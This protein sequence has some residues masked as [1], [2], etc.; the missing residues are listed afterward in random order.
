MVSLLPMFVAQIAT[1][2]TMA[3]GIAGFFQPNPRAF[4]SQQLH[5]GADDAGYDFTAPLKAR[6]T[7]L[8]DFERINRH[9]TRQTVGAANV[10]S[11]ERHCFDSRDRPLSVRHIM[12]SGAL[13]PAFT[14]VRI[15][16]ELFWDGGILSNKPVEAVFDDYPRRSGL[17]FAVRI[18]NP[19]GVELESIVQ[20]QNRPKDLQYSRRVATDIARQKQL[21]RPC[22]VIA[23]LGRLLLE[24]D[25]QRGDDV[26]VWVPHPH[27]RRP[28]TGA[29]GRGRESH[30]G[31][32]FQPVQHPGTL[33]GR[34]RGHP[35]I[36][37]VAPWEG[38]FGPLEGFIL[39]EGERNMAISRK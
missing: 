2:F 38:T 18:W 22:H 14:A 39:H 34:L 6:L 20:V 19:H 1:W 23:E 27:A 29:F 12:A 37:A 5:L 33:D 13:P 35:A 17:V 8:V 11:R 7:D 24:T 36:L 25:R 26:Q 10:R 32:R 3:G 9:T 31:Y 4:V 30:A 28:A 16:N 15:D 21:H